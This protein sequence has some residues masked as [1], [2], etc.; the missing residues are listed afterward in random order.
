MAAKNVYTVSQVN[1]YIKN[2]FQQDFL[3]RNLCVRGEVSN[4]KYHTSGHIYF[5]LKDEKGTLD[6][7]MFAGKRS[8]LAFRL[9]KGQQ[10]L[11]TGA[12]DVYERDGTYRLYA[13]RITRD[14]AGLLYERYEQLKR[15]LEERGMFA[16]EYK[17][18]LPRYIRTLGIVTA[19]D[20]AA[21]RDIIQVARRRDPGVQLI[22]CPA[23]VQGEGAAESIVRGIRALERFGVDVMIVGRGG[24]SIEDLWAFNEEAVAQAIFDCTVPVISAVGHETDTTIADYVADRRAPTPSAAAEL[25]VAELSAAELQIAEQ[26][27]RLGWAMTGKLTACRSS[28]ETYRLRLRCRSPE[29]RLREDRCRALQLEESLRE[30]MRQRLTDARHRLAL[31]AERMKG[32]SPLERLSRGFAYAEDAQGR[33]VRDVGQVS[34]GDTIALWVRNGRIDAAVTG[35]QKTEP[36]R[37]GQDGGEEK[38]VAGRK[39][40]GD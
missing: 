34:A 39:L 4:C 28:A 35:T 24:G 30:H 1:F 18:P 38:G 23:Q 16:E 8:G 7:M 20:G 31:H 25:A 40:P 9:E 2:M 6:C 10:V 12:A 13:V 15:E 17:Q 5:T 36:G 32:L 14:G 37:S 11:V 33:N 22:L 29:S 19:P 27:R 21:V 3:L 26:R